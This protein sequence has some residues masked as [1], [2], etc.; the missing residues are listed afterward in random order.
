MTNQQKLAIS[1]SDLLDLLIDLTAQIK[2]S[3][4]SM[5]INELMPLINDVTTNVKRIGDTMAIEEGQEAPIAEPIKEP[6]QN[7]VANKKK[8]NKNN[9][10][11]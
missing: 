8:V 9:V 6:K 7:V 3:T 4:D 5:E 1:M 10:N 11:K 2:V